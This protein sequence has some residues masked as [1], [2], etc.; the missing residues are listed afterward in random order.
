M[1][2]LL[3][4][5]KASWPL[6][7][8]LV[9]TALIRLNFLDYPFERDEGLY[10]YF[11]SLILEGKTPLKDFYDT[12]PMGLFYMYA[13]IIAIFGKSVQGLHIAF[14][15]VNLANILLVFNICKKIFSLNP[16]FLGALAFAI[17]SLNPHL[18]GPSI[19]SEHLLIFFMMAGLGFLLKLESDLN[20]GWSALAGLAFGISFIV[21]QN[22]IFFMTAGL[23]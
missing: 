20:P 5:L 9:M 10:A 17:L 22:G 8:I 15:L 14:L 18:G 2:G 3:N 11:A 16:A 19:L 21:K 23:I 12:K 6:M 1:D 7:V 13:V 4:K